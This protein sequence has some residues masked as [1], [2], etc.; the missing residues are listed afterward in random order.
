MKPAF[1]VGHD[2]SDADG[3]LGLHGIAEGG[4]VI[5]VCQQAVR[6]GHFPSLRRDCLDAPA[7]TARPH[8]KQRSNPLERKVV[9]DGNRRFIGECEELGVF[10]EAIGYRK[11]V[12]KFVIAF[13]VLPFRG[14]AGNGGLDARESDPISLDTE[15]A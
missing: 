9:A 13:D 3:V 7:F 2:V 12:C 11:F 15:L 6:V 1:V 8:P 5:E 14:L 10:L 4:S